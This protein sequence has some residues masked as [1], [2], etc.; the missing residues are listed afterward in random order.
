MSDYTST[1]YH[2]IIISGDTYRPYK[3]YNLHSNNPIIALNNLI[4]LYKSKEILNRFMIYPEIR[5]Y[6]YQNEE[7]KSEPD[8]LNYLT[9]DHIEFITNFI[10]TK[11]TTI[12]E[13]Q[14]I[15]DEL[16]TIRYTKHTNYHIIELMIPDTKLCRYL[17]N[18]VGWTE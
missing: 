5:D 9:E 14:K 3:V 1:T 10:K 17:N 16:S 6:I 8:M 13:A 4:Q 2:L 18:D 12:D 15:I 7:Y 11:N